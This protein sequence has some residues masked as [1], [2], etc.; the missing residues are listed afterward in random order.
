MVPALEKALS[1]LS[2]ST[3]SAFVICPVFLTHPFSTNTHPHDHI[4]NL[5]VVTINTAGDLLR[6]EQIRQGSQYGQ[7]IQTHIKEGTI[8]PMEIT[9]RLLEIAM[10]A[11]IEQRAGTPGWSGK[12]GRF[13]I[14]G[15]PRKMD[16]AIMFE[17]SVSI[18]HQNHPRLFYKRHTSQGLSRLPRPLLLHL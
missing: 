8:V 1:L 10:A 12:T 17:Q 2:W 6:Q 9:I 15:F 13:L 5:N 3:S 16:Q 18:H 14:D 7:I 4:H 11:A